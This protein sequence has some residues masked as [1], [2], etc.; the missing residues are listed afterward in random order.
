MSF[1][2][3]LKRTWNFIWHEDSFASFLVNLI[4]A[5]LIVK[6]LLYPGLGLL[7][8]TH[9]PIVAVVSGSME[10]NSMDFDE[11]WE[12]NKEWYLDNDITKEEFDNFPLENGFNKGDIVALHGYGNIEVGDIIV[13]KGSLPYPIIHR[14]VEINEDGTYQ[15]KGDNNRDS[16]QDELNISEEKIYGKAYIRLPWFGWVKILAVDLFNLIVR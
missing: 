6:Y 12:E 13:F 10:H 2:K 8:A 7:F 4:L 15:T 3:T 5:F 14:V 9:F 11:W 16:R 1:K